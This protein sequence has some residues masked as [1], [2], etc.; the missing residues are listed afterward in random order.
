MRRVAP[1][2]SRLLRH[3]NDAMVRLVYG[4]L[5]EWQTPGI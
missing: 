2:I 3:R 1:L 4:P 5:A